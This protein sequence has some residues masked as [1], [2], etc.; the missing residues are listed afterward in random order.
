MQN[1]SNA[2]IY[3]RQLNHEWALRY[4]HVPEI[5]EKNKKIKVMKEKLKDLQLEFNDENSEIENTDYKLINY[6]GNT[7][8]KS[9]S[10]VPKNKFFQSNAID[11]SSFFENVKLYLK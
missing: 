9:N 6:Q 8:N 2:E 11:S 1:S 3:C 5:I 4:I 10:F 7:G